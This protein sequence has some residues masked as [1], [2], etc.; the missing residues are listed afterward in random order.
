MDKGGKMNKPERDLVVGDVVQIDPKY[1]KMFEGSFGIEPRSLKAEPWDSLH[2]PILALYSSYADTGLVKVCP[3][4]NRH[5]A[6]AVTKDPKD[7]H[8]L[9]AVLWAG[10]SRHPYKDLGRDIDIAL[11]FKTLTSPTFGCGYC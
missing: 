6:V 9:F 8:I 4:C 11:T 7:G 2:E 3:R 10:R 1:A 5:G